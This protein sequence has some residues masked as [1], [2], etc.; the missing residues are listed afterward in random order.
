M[1]RLKPATHS[2]SHLIERR[3]NRRISYFRGKYARE[4]S[5][6]AFVSVVLLYVILKS[7]S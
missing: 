4:M 6:L 1:K 7:Q 2:G 3:K 5:M